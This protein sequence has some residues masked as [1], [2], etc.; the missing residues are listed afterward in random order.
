MQHQEMHDFKPAQ[1]HTHIDY[2]ESEGSI[3]I[4]TSSLTFYTYKVL[5]HFTI[6]SM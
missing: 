4:S 1:F 2:E 5:S 3:E 6:L